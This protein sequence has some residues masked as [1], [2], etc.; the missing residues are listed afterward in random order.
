MRLAIV[1]WVSLIIFCAGTLL[2]KENVP[3]VPKGYTALWH[4][5]LGD[6]TILALRGA[7]TAFN[8][9]SVV[10]IATSLWALEELGPGFI[11]STR[12]ALVGT[13]KEKGVFDGD[14]VVIGGGDPDFQIENAYLVAQ[15][16]NDMGI[17]EVRGHL[18]LGEGFWIG[19]E[20]GGVKYKT[21]K[22]RTLLMGRRLKIAFNSRYWTTDT[23]QA[24]E[25]FR[26][27]R[28]IT[29]HYPRVRV[30][31]S[32]GY[33]DDS[34]LDYQNIASS[35]A[36]IH[37]S[38][39]LF[40]M[41]GRMNRYSNNDIERLRYILGTPEECT[42]YLRTRLG[43]PDL[44]VDSLSGLGK[45]RMTLNDMIKLLRE[46]LATIEKNELTI[47]QILPVAGTT[48]GETV[49]TLDKK[50]PRIGEELRYAVVAKT[51]TLSNRE[52]AIA[53]LCGYVWTK[54]GWILF[55]VALSP[56]KIK[57]DW[58]FSARQFIAEWL[59]D[60]VSKGPD[61]SPLY[62]SCDPRF[63]DSYAEVKK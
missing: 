14:L 42:A 25:F 26:T 23:K 41:L 16:L 62:I 57:K 13:L 36:V 18:L 52:E 20:G 39:P 22:E 48:A 4:A 33:Y 5:E 2:G 40:V 19:W 9:A 10:K 35:P 30:R 21:P 59:I 8:P 27:R 12:F 28:G 7:D 31:K 49:S 55:C 15:T 1:C 53:V 6:G 61:P 11:F 32:V 51:G 29:G 38:N 24:I 17:R 43:S 60:L 44:V 63:S 37:R 47:S 45:S 56:K 58:P 3:V 54:K 46:F 50:F 34:R